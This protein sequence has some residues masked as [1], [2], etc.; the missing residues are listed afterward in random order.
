ML[1]VD[2][3]TSS[4]GRGPLFIALAGHFLRGSGAR[5][6]ALVSK[7]QLTGWPWCDT[8]ALNP[9]TY[10]EMASQAGLYDFKSSM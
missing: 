9:I 7:L 10:S 1:Q 3:Y 8:L 2:K 6:L 5:K 4:T